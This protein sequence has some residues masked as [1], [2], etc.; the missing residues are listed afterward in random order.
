MAADRL[1]LRLG[2]GQALELREHRRGVVDERHGQVQVVGER[3][4]HALGLL[5]AQQAVVDEHAVEALAEDLVHER[6]GD[7]RVDAARQRADRV[8]L[9]ADLLGDQPQLRLEHLGHRPV[10]LEAGDVE[11]KVAQRVGAAL[12]VHHLGVVLEAEDA[13]RRVLDRDDGALLAAADAREAVG[14]LGRLV[15]VRH[16]DVGPVVG[17]AGAVGVERRAGGDHDRHAAVLAADLAG[18]DLAMCFECFF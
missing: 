18:R 5:V 2:V 3:L 8:V 13:P 17:R 10:R 9:G 1:A 16:P 11:Q 4:H 12:G 6:R 14:Q 7:R 15:A